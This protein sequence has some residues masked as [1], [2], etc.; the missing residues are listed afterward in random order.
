MN[1]THLTGAILSRDETPGV[2]GPA[3]SGFK[4]VEIFTAGKKES[5]GFKMTVLFF[6]ISNAIFPCGEYAETNISPGSGRGGSEV[7]L[8]LPT[9]LMPPSKQIGGSEALTRLL[10]TP[11]L[12]PK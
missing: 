3:L 2:D 4:T 1:K 5:R 10:R 9:P 11:F 7:E 8:C 6:V 12:L